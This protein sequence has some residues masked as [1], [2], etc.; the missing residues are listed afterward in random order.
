M[1]INNLTIGNSSV[2][3]NGLN[4]GQDKDN[5]SISIDLD[6]DP[7]YTPGLVSKIMGKEN[8]IIDQ[9]D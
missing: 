4:N 6:T 8:L 2:F 5:K 7:N 9:D 3:I 1:L